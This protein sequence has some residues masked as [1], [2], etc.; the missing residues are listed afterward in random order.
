MHI[1]GGRVSLTINGQQYTARGEVSISP[2]NVETDVIVNQNGR[3][4]RVVKPVARTAEMTFDRL[5]LR[6]DEGILG[7]KVVM[8]VQEQDTGK[9]HL[10]TEAAFVGKPTINT[11][12][13]EVTGL[14]LAA[15]KYEVI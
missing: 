13:G 10:F 2:S 14:S 12:N 9:V 4:A 11:A 7:A 8:S 5:G 3:I 1:A 15:E 6:W